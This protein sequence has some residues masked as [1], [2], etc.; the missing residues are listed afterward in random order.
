MNLRLNNSKAFLNLICSILVVLPVLSAH[1]S[2]ITHSK[3]TLA[4]SSY[5]LNLNMNT[6]Q[7][8][9]QYHGVM[10]LIQSGEMNK[11]KQV[12]AMMLT[13]NP[14][15]IYALDISGNLLLAENKIPNAIDAFQRVLKKQASADVMSKLGATYLL[16]G[17]LENA[18]LWLTQ[19][20]SL[21]PH[22]ALAL[23]YLAWLEGQALNTGIQLHYLN[24][25]VELNS[26]KNALY[27]YHVIYLALL[28]ETNRVNAGLDFIA[29]AKP[30]LKHSQALVVDNVNLLETELLLKSGQLD[31]AKEQFKK[32]PSTSTDETYIVN[33]KIVAVLYN[34]SIK[35]F[36]AAKSIIKDSLSDN[37]E[38]K[39]LAQHTLATAYFDQS[40][41]SAAHELLV[42]NL[43]STDQL[44]RKMGFIDDILANFAAQSRYGDAIKFLKAQIND[45]PDIPQYQHQL[46]ELYIISGRNK[47]ANK[48]L[49]KVIADFP[50]YAPSYIVKGRRLLKKG[51]V[52]EITTFYR[53][54]TTK[55]PKVAELWTDLASYYVQQEMLESALTTLESGQKH[56]DSNL[57][58]TFELASL[59]DQSM[60]FALSEPLYIKI[61]QNYPEYLPAL[62]NLASNY[63]LM[64]KKL[65]IAIVLAKRAYLISPD[66][67]FI[68]NLRAQAYIAENK[69]EEAIALMSPIILTFD[70]SG[71]GNYTLAQAYFA[72][73]N[74]DLA[75]D[76]LTQALN[77]HLPPAVRT[78]AMKLQSARN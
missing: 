53:Q 12:L 14:N 39:L 56:N 2:I 49:D 50:Q 23:R 67:I 3:N 31:K 17:N 10:Q 71:V 8:V 61:L 48:Q 11:A 43:E 7:Y 33:Y 9:G 32:L 51:T 60:Q 36:Q 15:D 41:Y 63:F 35:D 46:A 54:A 44:A 18:K 13:Q 27:E 6:Q 20:L 22:N 26:E 25:L 24:K 5:V 76:N 1:A 66:D 59:Y 78:K 19:A 38:A 28:S 74:Q 40:N 21:N 77:K 75:A 29:Q 30:K 65:D 42:N 16:D 72:A 52:E 58:L 62:D 37:S 69:N 4:D 34:A 73:G 57:L 64:E 45:A 47:A 70:N 55:L 68:K